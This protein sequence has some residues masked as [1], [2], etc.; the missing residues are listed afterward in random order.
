MIRGAPAITTQV[1][2]QQAAPGAQITD[3]AVVTGLGKLAAT[4]NVELWGPFPTRAAIRCEGTP[5]WTGSSRRTATA[6]TPP[7]RSRSRRGLLHLPR[8]D[9][10]DARVDAVTTACGEA[11]ETTFA[12]AAPAVTTIVSS[13]AV[14]PGRQLFDRIKVTGL[15]KTPAKVGVELFGPFASRAAIRCD[16]EPYWSGSVDVP[17][18]GEFRSPRATVRKVGFY[19]YR[20][21]I[22]GSESVTAAETE[23]GVEAETS[24]GAPA[25]HHRPRRPRARG[26][27]RAGRGTCRKP[28]RVRSPRLGIDAPVSAMGIDTKAGALGTP[29]N[30]DRVGWWRDGAAP[31]AK[32]GTIL[33]A[34]HVDSAKRGAG[35]FY[36]LKR[37]RRGDRIQLRSR[38]ADEELAR[39]LDEDDAQG[40]APARDLHAQRAAAARAR[41]LRRAVR[42]ARATTATTSSSP[43][44]RS[45][46]AGQ[47]LASATTVELGPMTAATT[48]AMPSAA[49]RACAIL[50][51]ARGSSA[52]TFACQ[53]AWVRR[54]SPTMR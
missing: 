54:S 11:A 46:R 39:H 22:A 53:P 52:S 24:L 28:T 41:H 16:R 38:R 2:A 33:L 4:V 17:G 48:S 3:T 26:G 5:V 15:G 36:G 19:T 9:R 13:T 50:R 42:R 29:V 30:I 25:D 44:S 20:E 23:C 12:K 6:A 43:P 27:G 31:G 14:K 32:S 7:R 49:A 1:S 8:G 47:L 45:R 34:G 40:V 10:G 35:A 37:A 51:A 21:R 18:D